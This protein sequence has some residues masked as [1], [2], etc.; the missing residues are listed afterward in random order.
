MVLGAGD[1]E[2]AAADYE[3]PALKRQAR[4]SHGFAASRIEKHP[5]G[6]D[7]LSHKWPFPGELLELLRRVDQQISGHAGLKEP[8]DGVKALDERLVR[9]HDDDEINILL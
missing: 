4:S 9:P 2:A 5:L 6:Q 3:Q 8:P 7:F 1:P